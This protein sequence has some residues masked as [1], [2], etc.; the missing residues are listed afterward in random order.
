MQSV[1]LRQQSC[2]SSAAGMAL[3]TTLAM[4][5]AGRAFFKLGTEAG[6]TWDQIRQAVEAIRKAINDGLN[7]YPGVSQSTLD[8]LFEGARTAY[9]M[10]IART[11][12]LLAAVLLIGGVIIWFGMRKSTR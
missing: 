6:L 8:Q 9:S 2:L 5:F 7:T 12:L 1:F 3:S 4:A 11:T 10:G